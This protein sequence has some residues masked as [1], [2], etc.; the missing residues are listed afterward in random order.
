[1]TTLMSAAPKAT[2]Q[3][4]VR[5]SAARTI[6]ELLQV[7]AEASSTLMIWKKAKRFM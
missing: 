2:A 4:T 5:Q 7:V 1:M 6:A 3:Q